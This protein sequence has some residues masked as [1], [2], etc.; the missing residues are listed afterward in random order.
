[1][2]ADKTGDAVCR[3]QQAVDCRC[4]DFDRKNPQRTI[5]VTLKSCQLL[6]TVITFNQLILMVIDYIFENR[7]ATLI[8]TA[9]FQKDKPF[10]EYTTILSVWCRNNHLTSCRR[11]TYR[12]PSEDPRKGE[13]ER[14]YWYSYIPKTNKGIIMKLCR[15]LGTRCK[16]S[17]IKETLIKSV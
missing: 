16:L 9:E 10:N 14:R 8:L 1:M 15:D 5:H 2:T 7:Q 17:G 12:V 3:L 11:L 6:L 13:R 4:I